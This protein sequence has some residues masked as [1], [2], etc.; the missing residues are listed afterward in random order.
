MLHVYIKKEWVCE[1]ASERECFN[2][3]GPTHWKVW[4]KVLAFGKLMEMDISQWAFSQMLPTFPLIK[5][6][7]RG[8]FPWDNVIVGYSL[9]SR[10]RWGKIDLKRQS[11]TEKQLFV[12]LRFQPWQDQETKYVPK[13]TNTY[14]RLSSDSSSGDFLRYVSVNRTSLLRVKFVYVELFIGEIPLVHE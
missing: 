14:W 3:C 10:V 9:D 11:Q 8:T 4:R 1:R 13:I 12:M 6:S 5:L 7:S 2:S